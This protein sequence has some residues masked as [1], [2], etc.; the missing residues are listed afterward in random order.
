MTLTA[1]LVNYQNV[2]RSET[3]AVQ[4]NACVV[5]SITPTDVPGDEIYPLGTAA[6]DVPFT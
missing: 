3:F 5:T 4:I 6:V 2:T 1:T